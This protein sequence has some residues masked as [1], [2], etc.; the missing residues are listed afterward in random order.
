L[1][2]LLAGRQPGIGQFGFDLLHAAGPLRQFGLQT[3][4]FTLDLLASGLLRFQL[5]AE[6]E[7]LR[8][9][10]LLVSPAQAQIPFQSLQALCLPGDLF[11]K[12]GLAIRR[13]VRL[14]P[15]LSQQALQFQSP[16][17]ILSSL[18]AQEIQGTAPLLGLGADLVHFLFQPL[19]FRS[20]RL[21]GPCLEILEFSGNP[22]G[23]PAGL[24][25]SDL[26]LLQVLFGLLDLEDQLDVLGPQALSLGC[27]ALVLA[28]QRFHQA[29]QPQLGRSQ[30]SGLEM[31]G[32]RTVI[33]L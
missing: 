15:D 18:L 13:G 20:Q 7:R 1:S 19:A 17:L 12:S 3:T 26:G 16:A 11:G 2:P 4:R 28:P 32:N 6:P 23:F 8:L 14:G 33:L 10:V 5:L 27:Q 30:R 22:H 29:H 9:P 25:Q 24:V 21:F 31:F